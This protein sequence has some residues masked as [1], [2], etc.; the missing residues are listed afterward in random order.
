MLFKSSIKIKRLLFNLA[1]YE[2]ISGGGILLIAGCNCVR[3]PLGGAGYQ[4]C[5]TP[6]GAIALRLVVQNQIQQRIVHFDM[7]V[8]I[9]VA[10]FAELVHELIYA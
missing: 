10:E 3:A 6:L 5:N 7:T 1:Q 4:H 9:D 2:R 8:V